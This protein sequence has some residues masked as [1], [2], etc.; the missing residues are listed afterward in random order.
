M[1]LRKPY[2]LLIK[3][4]KVIHIIITVFMAYLMYKMVNLYKFFNGYVL[5]GWSSINADEIAGY[6]G[7]LIYIS[8]AIIIALALIVFF[9]MRFKNKPRLY[10]LLTPIVYTVLLFIFIYS[11]SILKS[12]EVDV[13]NPVTV[14]IIRDITMISVVVEFIFILFSLF[15]SIGFDIKKFNFKQDIAD[16]QIQELD[17]EEV[18]VNFE[19]DKYKLNRKFRRRFRNIKYIFSEH[20]FIFTLII[21]LIIGITIVIFILNTFVLKPIYRE[22]KLI[23]TNNFNFTVTKSYI[24]TKDYLGEEL[25]KNSKYVLVNLSIINKIQELTLD[26]DKFSININNE[27]YPAVTN[28]YSD[29]KDL[30][31]G[32]I[33]QKLTIGKAN[34]YFLVFKI[35]RNINSNKII[36]R[37]LNEIAYDK[38]GSQ[39]NKYKSVK[40][41]VINADNTNII[42][43]KIGD[44]SNI[45]GTEFTIKEYNISDSFDYKYNFCIKDDDCKTSIAHVTPSG[46]NSTILKL[47]VDS[48]LGENINSSIKDMSYYFKE[49]GSIVYIKDG[50][51]YKQK[52]LTNLTTNF[53]GTEIFLNV[54]N[55]IKNSSEIKFEISNRNIIYSYKLK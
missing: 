21:S 4:F 47:T 7:P 2:A 10:Y 50:K 40:L 42:N 29:F 26:T 46:Y 11:N 1:V 41:N 14:R 45:N 36:F 33:N 54:T 20:S 8:I 18:E 15:R 25:G 48:K 3:Y 13:I 32:Y 17:N 37:Y 53:N 55:N 39:I 49:F 5:S 34:N 35:P 12:A 30:G 24:T 31:N 27:S 22:G 6:I 51:R 19:I 16:L 38:N 23:K 43:K 44:S 9:L 28:I 52:K